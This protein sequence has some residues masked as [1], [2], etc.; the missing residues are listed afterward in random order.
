MVGRPLPPRRWG[1]VPC[2]VSASPLLETG[3][4]DPSGNRS[5][6]GYRP[7]GDQNR[8]FPSTPAAPVSSRPSPQIP[9]PAPISPPTLS[10]SLSLA[11]WTHP[12]CRTDTPRLDPDPEYPRRWRWGCT[13][14]QPSTVVTPPFLGVCFPSVPIPPGTL[15][16]PDSVT[17]PRVL[18]LGEV[19]VV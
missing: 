12:D 11:G 7:S 14:T 2:L 5:G 9:F 3:T 8:F 6:L 19:L 4:P 15:H 1:W 18:E 17:D 16:N 13:V 10:V